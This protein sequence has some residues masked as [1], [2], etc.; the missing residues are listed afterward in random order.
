MRRLADEQIGLAHLRYSV[1]MR[2]LTN[3]GMAMFRVAV[4]NNRLVAHEALLG[5]LRRMRWL[6]LAVIPLNLLFVAVFWWMVG[7]GDVRQV[8]WRQASGWT[9]LLMAGWLALCGLAAH[10]FV[11]R[12]AGSHGGQVL[13]VVAPLSVMLFTVAL[14]AVDQRVTSSISPYLLGSAFVSIALLMRPWVALLVH[15]LAFAAFWGG[16]DLMQPDPVQLLI[17]RL[18]GLS[19]MVLGIVLSSLLWRKNTN[20]LLLQR[21]LESRNQTLLQ[22]REDLVWLAKHDG[23]TGLLNRIEF[24]RLAEAELL[25]AQRHGTD[26]SAIMVDLD[27]FKAINDKYGHPA[28]DRVLKHTAEWLLGGVR[29][30][31]AV[32]R[33]GGEEFIVLLPQTAQPAALAVAEK[34]LRTL[35]QSPVPLRGD[36]AIPIT[37]SLGVGTLPAGHEGS[38]AALYAAADHALYEAKHLGRNRVEKTEPDGSLTPSD[39]QRMRRN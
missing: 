24:L 23:L 32:A 22:Q 20:Y 33:V 1:T 6:V 18:N 13:Q 35:Q 29:A 9:H 16:M 15:V 31:D 8:A 10:H 2:S 14:A 39:F 11:K 27:F 5:N 7:G 28:G 21:E 36:L 25:R 37:A 38:V 34:L 19:A 3:R 12:P 26:T 30:T 17:N 4:A